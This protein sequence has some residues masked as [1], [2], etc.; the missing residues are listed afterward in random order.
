MRY[1][2][3]ATILAVFGAVSQQGALAQAERTHILT[4]S[5]FFWYRV[6]PA[7]C[8]A[9]HAAAARDPF[10]VISGYATPEGRVAVDK[11]LATMRQQGQ[12]VIAL[13]LFHEHGEPRNNTMLD[14]TGGKLTTEAS[15]AVS[16]LIDKIV[17][18]DFRVLYIRF[19]PSGKNYIPVT[20]DDPLSIEPD[21]YQE[22]LSIIEH[23]LSLTAGK[24]IEVITDLC[25]ECSP[26]S[27][28][29][30]TRKDRLQARLMVYTSHLWSDYVRKHGPDHTVGFSIIPD[31][32]RAAN[33]PAVYSQGG[34]HPGMLDFH[35]YPSDTDVDLLRCKQDP[36]GS[37]CDV[38][39]ACKTSSGSESC[40]SLFAGSL[41]DDLA[42]Q[43][44]TIGFNMPWI[45]GE[46]FYNDRKTALYL[47]A[48]IE[49]THQEIKYIVQWPLRRSNGS[50]R[51]ACD[52]S[53]NGGGV[54]VEAPVDVDAY[55]EIK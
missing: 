49:L 42:H 23:V 51:G 3:T 32:F 40:R 4:G 13:G 34:V 21:I 38:T 53:R 54:N 31:K 41:F 46:T 6:D 9:G 48:G 24:K 45:V 47:K 14:S 25:N 55:A 17:A 37:A 18:L 35:F 50:E 22:N 19:F 1:L 33:L 11:M 8:A 5:N 39:N 12:Q 28:S 27:P 43:L 26:S 30:D 44:G 7:R 29:F 16:A 52:D 20:Y 10:A 36:H 2:A 15:L